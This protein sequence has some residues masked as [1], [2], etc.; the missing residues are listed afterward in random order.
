[1]ARQQ[2]YFLNALLALASFPVGK[3]GKGNYEFPFKFT[4]PQ[5]VFSSLPMVGSSDNHFG[6][7]YDAYACLHTGETG[8][9]GGS[10][11]IAGAQQFALFSGLTNVPICPAMVDP[12][13][14]PITTFCC[15]SNGMMIGAMQCESTVWVPGKSYDVSFYL[16]NNS[17]RKIN[18]LQIK[19]D[20]MCSWSA[21]GHYG[22]YAISP[23]VV[24]MSTDPDNNTTGLDNSLLAN[25]EEPIVQDNNEL[26]KVRDYIYSGKTKVRITCPANVKPDYKGTTI[27]LTHRLVLQVEMPCCTENIELILPIQVVNEI[28]VQRTEEPTIYPPDYQIQANQFAQQQAQMHSQLPQNWNATVAPV[29]NVQYG[30]WQAPNAGG[31]P[32]AQPVPGPGG[33][34][35][36]PVG[37]L[38]SSLQATFTPTVE[39][40]NWIREV[41]SRSPNLGLADSDFASIF[42]VI[43]QSYAQIEVASILSMHLTSISCSALCSICDGCLEYNKSEVLEK[44]LQK[45]PVSD[46]GNKA[47]L[48]SKLS[49]FQFLNLDSKYLN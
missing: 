25:H 23:V 36:S 15:C 2:V 21:N 46:K 20:E 13:F 16:Q 18:G 31:L 48:Q 33:I 28:V 5:G 30:G 3:I 34:G 19:F 38:I 49:N 37:T 42:K 24:N 43:S 4:I 45:V 9:F 14:Y 41:G 39:L 8:F 11:D 27:T 40:E 26:F 17:T 44:V 29:A 22:N 32:T 12:V 1:M 6:I 10:N 47:V 35:M 7:T